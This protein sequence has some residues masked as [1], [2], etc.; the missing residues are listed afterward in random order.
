MFQ[1]VSDSNGLVDEQKLTYLFQSL[2]QI[3]TLCNEAAAFGGLLVDFSVRSCLERSNKY[4]IEFRDFLL[5]VQREPQS[6]V[7]LAVF[8]RIIHSENTKHFNVRCC[9]CKIMPITGLRYRCMKCFNTDFCQSC[10]FYGHNIR[11][12][13]LTHAMQEYCVTTT[14]GL[15]FYHFIIFNLT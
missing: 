7:W 2:L 11:G 13:K 8:H 3:P 10:F 1:L 9:V 5:W 4:E 15:L 14:A 12:H 6:L